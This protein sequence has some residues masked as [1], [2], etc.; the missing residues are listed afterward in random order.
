[1]SLPPPKTSASLVG[2][3]VWRIYQIPVEGRNTATSDLPSPS[4]SPVVCCSDA[5]LRA[6]NLLNDVLDRGF[7]DALEGWDDPFGPRSELI[8]MP[9]QEPT[10]LRA[11]AK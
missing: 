4:K 8:D 9:L 5:S 1:M 7:A 6:A 10:I 3:A 11:Q 2:V